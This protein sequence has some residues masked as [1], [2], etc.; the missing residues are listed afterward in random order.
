MTKTTKVE[1]EK[2]RALHKAATASP[3]FAEE[4]RSDGLMV[5]DDGRL[6]GLFDIPAEVPE[7]KLIVAMRNNIEDLLD[8]MEAA[9][10]MVREL[11]A[12]NGR[13]R[14]RIVDEQITN[15]QLRVSQI[16]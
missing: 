11:R 13:L 2:L 7:A 3:W 14:I 12:E 4:A 10:K 9:E 15:E 5:I 6:N 1:R 16:P 8:D